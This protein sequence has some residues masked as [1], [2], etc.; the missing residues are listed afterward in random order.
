M[1]KIYN[2]LTGQWLMFDNKRNESNVVNKFLK[3]DA[4]EAEGTSGTANKVDF[5]SNGIKIRENNGDLNNST[6]TN[7]LYMAFAEAPIVGSNNVPATAR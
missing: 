1:K 4:N 5:L 2:G 7:Y 3:T 6:S